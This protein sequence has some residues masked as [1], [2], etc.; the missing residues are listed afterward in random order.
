MMLASGQVC[1]GC[2]K[3][4]A[5]P[6]WCSWSQIRPTHNTPTHNTRNG[7]RNGC[8]VARIAVVRLESAFRPS[9]TFGPQLLSTPDAAGDENRTPEGRALTPCGC[10]G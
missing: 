7:A 8:T 2:S 3:A 9:S 10:M 6:L 4:G 1:Y 5:S